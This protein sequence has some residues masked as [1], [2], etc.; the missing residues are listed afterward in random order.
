MFGKLKNTR[1]HFSLI[2]C[3]VIT[4]FSFDSLSAQEQEIK[5]DQPADSIYNEYIIDYKKRFN[6]KLE[7][8]NDIATYDI[9]NDG[10]EL[11]LKPNL[12]LRYAVVFSYKFLS[13]RLGIRPKI[14]DEQKEEK[15]GSDTFRLRFQLLFDN[16][17]HVLQYSIDKGYYVSNTADFIDTDTKIRLQFPEMTSNV[18]FGASSL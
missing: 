2:L 18:F 16:W 13:V 9:V 14:S 12:N 7:V 8:S 15:G 11:A 17:N 5:K 6:V 1:F 10:L 3:W 4:I